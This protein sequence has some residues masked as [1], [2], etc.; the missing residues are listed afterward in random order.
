VDPL[1]LVTPPG[2]RRRAATA[3]PGAYPARA[4]YSASGRTVAFA[5]RDG[6]V[7]LWDTRLLLAPT[8]WLEG[9]DGL[10]RCL[11][12][13]PDGKRLATGDA[14]GVVKLWDTRTGLE[15][16][17]LPA[18]DRAVNGVAFSPDG[19]FL[20]TAGADRTVKVWDGS[21]RESRPKAEDKKAEAEDEESP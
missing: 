17:S 6:S 11:A 5:C 15:V 8:R 21:S 9:H 1:R 16:L 19:Q 3:L 4:A 13:S 20:Y 14:E 18:H 10:V 12:F 2:A 7:L